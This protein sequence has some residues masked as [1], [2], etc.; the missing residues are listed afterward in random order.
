VL[1]ICGVGIAV[2]VLGREAT[3]IALVGEPVY[4]EVPPGRYWPAGAVICTVPDATVADAT[5]ADA[6][7]AALY[8]EVLACGIAGVTAGDVDAMVDGVVTAGVTAFGAGVANAA[9]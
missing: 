4:V 7:D 3:S 8:G 6:T 5:V 9:P 2:V 1:G